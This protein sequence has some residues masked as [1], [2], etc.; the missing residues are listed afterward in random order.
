MFT[1]SCI[2]N[3]KIQKK[4]K[5][6]LEY[7]HTNLKDVLK[8]QAECVEF[9]FNIV[10][11]FEKMKYVSSKENIQELLPDIE[12][13]IIEAVKYMNTPSIDLSTM[14][15][16]R[17]DFIISIQYILD[18]IDISQKAKNDLIDLKQKLIDTDNVYKQIQGFIQKKNN[19]EL[20]KLFLGLKN[21]NDD[22]IL[23]IKE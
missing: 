15:K 22:A 16:E 11:F 21:M 18:N 13:V 7:L 4:T 23:G 3:E 6:H 17:Y 12:N 9:T 2:I 8:N 20:F 1:T 14:F 5:E 19:E 10:E